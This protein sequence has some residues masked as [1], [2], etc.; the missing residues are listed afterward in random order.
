MKTAGTV[1]LFLSLLG[2]ILILPAQ[3]ARSG[4]VPGITDLELARRVERVRKEFN[5]PGIAIAIVSENVVFARGYGDRTLDGDPVDVHTKFCIASITKSFTATAIEMLA[6][7]GKLRLD[8]RVIDHLPWFRMA[9]PYVSR[10]IRVRD[11]LAHR[12]GLAEHAGDLLFVPPTTYSTREVVEHLRNLPLATGFRDSFAYENIMFAVAALIIEQVSGQSYGDFVR[13]RIFQPIG[14]TESV[15]D[16]TYLAQRD[17]V[18]AAYTPQAD[19]RLMLV[20]P[21]AWKNNPGA[22]GIYASVRDM[23]RWMQA[24][25]AGGSTGGAGDA[26]QRLVSESAQRRMWSVITPIEIDPPVVP[27]LQPA[28]PP[29]FG[30]GEGWYLSDYRSQRMVWHSGEFPGTASLLTLLPAAHLGIVVLSNQES[31]EALKSLTFEI[32]DG[33]LGDSK[34]DWIAAYSA[35]AKREEASLSSEIAKRGAPRSDAQR[36]SRPLTTYAGTY[37]DAW[38]GDVELRLVDGKLRMR[39][40]HSPRLVGSLSSWNA[41]T[42]SVRWDDQ[43]LNADAFI[44]F[45]VGKNGRVSEAHMHR[46]SPRTAHAY[47]FQDLRLVPK[48]N[49]SPRATSR[50]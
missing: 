16:S 34:T 4:T 2:C 25:M 49:N 7:D 44:D 9:D 47:N 14:M 46:A 32:L 33:Y 36:A 43:T 38:Y 48:R 39:F 40:S 20:P 30:Y 21:L 24:L 27:E 13:T 29:F 28:T 17:D 3:I 8:D 31:E 19:G 23:A 26:P 6:D 42:F 1:R 22:G 37:H 15:I 11:L 12:S 50:P 45:T 41:D 5:V 10:E 18:A 35:A